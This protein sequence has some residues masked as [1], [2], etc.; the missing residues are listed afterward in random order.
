MAKTAK[1][2]QA[3][4]AGSCT[5]GSSL[6]LLAQSSFI[7][8]SSEGDQEVAC[9]ATK[10]ADGGAKTKVKVMVKANF[11]TNFGT[12]YPMSWCYN[13]STIATATYYCIAIPLTYWDYP[14]ATPGY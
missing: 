14:A 1:K 3:W 2:Y 11:K 7:S 10:T 5:I 8:W 12:L 6:L 13:S 9:T 4:T